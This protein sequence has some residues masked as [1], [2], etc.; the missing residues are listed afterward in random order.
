MVGGPCL[1]GE[2]CFHG[3]A[4]QDL[5][6]CLL[7]TLLQTCETQPNLGC[8]KYQWKLENYDATRGPQ[9]TDVMS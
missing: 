4:G 2:M 6:P 3:A 1:G 5:A 8:P 9:E 7:E